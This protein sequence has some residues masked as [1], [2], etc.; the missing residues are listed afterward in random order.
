MERVIRRAVVTGG[1]GVIGAALLEELVRQNIE[2]LVLYNEGS[3]RIGNIKSHP[4]IRLHPCSLENLSS[5]SDNS[6]ERFDAFF[7]LAWGGTFGASRDDM[8]LQQRNVK[9]ALDAVGLAK[10]LGCQVFVG[11]GSQAEYGVAQEKLTSSTPTKPF[12]GYGMAKLCAGQMTRLYAKQIGIQHIWT[13]VLS[14]YGRRDNPA[15][16]VM[17]TIDKL[18]KSEIPK[19]TAGEQVWDYLYDQDAAAAFVAMAKFGRDGGIYPLGS[20]EGKPLKDYI[21]ILRDI[22][23]PTMNL[24]FGSIPYS[25]NQVMY[26]CADIEDL[27]KDTGWTPKISFEEGIRLIMEMVNVR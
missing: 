26:L 25:D 1:T 20:G 14:V 13:R 12:S 21:E 2:T 27:K 6:Q 4:L 16:M 15:T 5:F 22:V 9:F 23:N 18:L 3:K 7:H 11:A 10:R 19:L 24:D 8:Y 17:S